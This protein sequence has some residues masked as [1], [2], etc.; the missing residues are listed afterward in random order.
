M[1]IASTSSRQVRAL[2]A[3]ILLWIGFSSGAKGRLA[4]EAAYRA[5][6]PADLSSDPQ[7]AI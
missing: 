4:L 6:V 5:A 2:G 7:I 1:F 3:N